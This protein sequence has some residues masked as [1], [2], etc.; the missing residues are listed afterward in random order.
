MNAHASKLLTVL[1]KALSSEPKSETPITDKLLSGEVPNEVLRDGKLA[2][3]SDKTL[4]VIV[5]GVEICTPEKVE[6]LKALQTQTEA[7]DKKLERVST[8]AANADHRKQAEDITGAIMAGQSS[9]GMQIRSRESIHQQKRTEREA[10]LKLKAS[11]REQA[12]AIGLP[13]ITAA[14]TAVGKEMRK[15]EVSERA[16]AEAYGIVTYHSELFRACAAIILRKSKPAND[17]YQ[18]PRA[19]MA[20]I[21]EI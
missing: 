15:L 6:A 7:V 10:F 1:E 14:M 13:V 18:S 8:V 20:G 11:I 19:L 16:Q 4:H 3:V 17:P 21:I 5:T 12:L 2:L 9:E